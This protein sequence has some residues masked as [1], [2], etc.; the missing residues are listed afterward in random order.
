VLSTP[1]NV[2]TATSLTQRN[3]A[4]IPRSVV[5]RPDG[6]RLF[7]IH[8]NTVIGIQEYTLY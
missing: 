5:F 7:T 4:Y 8:S 2:E 3:L 6:L 1:W